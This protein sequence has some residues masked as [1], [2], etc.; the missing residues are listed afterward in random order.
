[1]TK[2]TPKLIDEVF[3]DSV[4]DALP[5]NDKLGYGVGASKRIQDP[6]WKKNQEKS[7][8]KRSQNETWL[9]KKRQAQ[10]QL[11]NDPEYIAKR[12][13]G[14]EERSKNPVNRK[15]Q[16]DG[17]KRRDTE[18]ITWQENKKAGTRRA[19]AKP[20]ITP[21]GIFA[22]G[23]E[24]GDAYNKS[25]GV[26]NGKNAVSKSLKAGKEGY[27]YISVEEYIMLTGKEL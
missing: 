8:A 27:K 19:L 12:Q 7:Q 18:N 10:A 4:L 25:R 3:D 2:I 16:L 24:A 11:E 13:K 5:T 23:V 17:I 21:L 22:T 15:K 6:N 20:C 1:M 26:T 9:S 14:I